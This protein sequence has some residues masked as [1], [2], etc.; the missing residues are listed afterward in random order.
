VQDWFRV[1]PLG[2]W[3]SWSVGAFSVWSVSAS[4]RCA[5]R[6]NLQGFQD[7]V[8][9]PSRSSRGRSQPSGSV[10][11][12]IPTPA[13]ALSDRSAAACRMDSTW[14]RVGVIGLQCAVD[15]FRPDFQH[16]SIFHRFFTANVAR[17]AFV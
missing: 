1:C 6:E 14:V 8:S 15:H 11:S 17:G 10:V 3:A 16:A 5:A 9:C 13:V 2:S 7:G 12:L 4:S